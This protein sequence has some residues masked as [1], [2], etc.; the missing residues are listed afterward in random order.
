MLYPG[1][2]VSEMSGT[3]ARTPLVSSTEK[4]VCAMVEAIETEKKSARVPAWPWVPLGVVIKRVPVGVLR[5][6]S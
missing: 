2:V 6:M 5:R 4:G 1:Y 3:S